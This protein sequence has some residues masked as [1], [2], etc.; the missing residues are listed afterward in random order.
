MKIAFVY[1]VIYPYVVGGVERRVWEL[2][3]RLA[4]R[5]HEVHI[6]G[7]KY[8]AGE[9]VI[10]KEGIFLH[11]VC[12][13]REIYTN[14][15]RSIGEALYFA[16]KVLPPLLKERFDVIDCQEFPYF[17]C[18]SAKLA[19]IT[20]RSK[21]IVTWHEVWDAYWYEYLGRKGFFG[22]YVEKVAAHLTGNIVAV[23][24]MTRQN[25]QKLGVQRNIDLIPNGI[26]FEAIQKIPASEEES[27]VIFAGRLIKEKNIDLLLRSL[28]LMK[29]NF[30]KVKC[31]IIGDGPEREAL[32]ELANELGLQGNIYWKGFLRNQ[33]EVLSYVKSSRVF[34]LPSV[35]E[36][37]GI[38]ALEANACGVPVVTVKH[39]QNAACDLV[40]DGEN[41]FVCELMSEDMAETICLLLNHGSNDKE[42]KACIQ[43]AGRY[44]WNQ[45]VSMT[46]EVYV[47]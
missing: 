3:I 31:T 5:G 30:P 39:H 23:S 19:S 6:F 27:D 20:K 35:R 44:D 7:M 9:D 26:D 43:Y 14:G 13:P 21:L 33:D 25:L 45:I 16:R 22:K 8:W 46:E 24:E 40:S 2:S 28:A 41:G 47:K 11:G 15:R 37:F 36:G 4:R 10:Q 29:G 42:D 38:V 32:E 18:F 17:P 12:P 1:D 34:A